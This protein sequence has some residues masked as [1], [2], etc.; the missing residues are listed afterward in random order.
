MIMNHSALRLPDYQ[1]LTD[2]MAL[3]SLPLSGSQLHGIICGYLCAGAVSGA[4]HYLQALVLKHREA[5]Q[6]QAMLVLFDVFAVSQQQISEFD[7]GFQLMLPDDHES[8]IVRA[9]AFSEWCEGFSNGLELAGIA[10]EQ[11]HDQEAQEAVHHIE[12]FAKLD[13][14]DLDIG[15]TDE[16]ALMEVSEYARIAVLRLHG[17]LLRQGLQVSDTTGTTH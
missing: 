4:E 8:L 14:D 12:E 6:R 2:S 5:Q 15:E 1:T 10:A 13:Y 7:F 11:F 16:H 9:Q 3:L 17:D